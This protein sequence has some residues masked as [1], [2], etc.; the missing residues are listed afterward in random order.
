MSSLRSIVAM[1]SI[2]LAASIPLACDLAIGASAAESRPYEKMA[3]QAI[4]KVRA[5]QPADVRLLDDGPQR[6]SLG[7]GTTAG[8]GTRR[9]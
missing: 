9:L 2:R 7:W 4:L 5:F 6:L 3:D 1:P 8:P